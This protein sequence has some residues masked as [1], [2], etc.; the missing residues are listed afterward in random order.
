MTNTVYLGLGSNIGNRAQNLIDG[1]SFL[2]SCGFAH[3]QKISSIYETSPIGP[4][5]R[6]FYNV[7]AKISTCLG[8]CDLLC[9]IKDIEK[10]MGRKK[11]IKWGARIIDIDI[12]FFGQ[13]TIESKEL[14]IPHKEIQNRL[15]VLI[16]LLEI[17]PNFKHSKFNGKIDK[18]LKNNLLT[19]QC[20]KITIVHP[21]R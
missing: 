3:L 17:A 9:L 5:Q 11:T 13:K 1:L 20:Q 6:N 4:N 12:L 21:R 14:I 10:L 15:F 2:E 8:P 19:L 18:I 7:V 16:P